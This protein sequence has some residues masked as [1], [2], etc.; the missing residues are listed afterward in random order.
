[1]V[2]PAKFAHVVYQ[3]RRYEEML[4][5]YCK[6]F[7]AEIV[8]QDPALA[9]LTYDDEHHRFAFANLDLLKSD[10]K[11]PD[12]RGTI[13]VNHVA[14]TYA[15]LGAL[16]E[17]YL[18]LK[19]EGIKPYWSI[20]HGITLSNY[21]RDPDGNRMEFQIDVEENYMASEVFAANP[22]GVDVDMD[23]LV[24][25]WRAGGDPLDL[26]KMPDGPMAPIPALHGMT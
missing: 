1:M 2:K 21:Y 25:R 16:L 26:I 3:T 24:I 6:V 20:H 23:A 4:A 7:E 14:Y 19:D 12:D 15:D 9:F 10:G 17:T 22:I 13:G 8:H 5:W 18:R 11:D